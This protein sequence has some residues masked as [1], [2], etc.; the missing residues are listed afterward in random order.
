VP[1]IH[2][3]AY[4]TKSTKN[5]RNSFISRRIRKVFQKYKISQR[6]AVPYF[7]GSRTTVSILVGLSLYS[8]G[9][10]SVKMGCQVNMSVDFFMEGVGGGAFS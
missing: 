7:L 3:C 4:L 1:V 2:F 6:T 9:K 10:T 5:E 8:T